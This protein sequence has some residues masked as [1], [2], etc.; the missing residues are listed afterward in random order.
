MRVLLADG[1]STVRSAL[2]VLLEQDPGL[3][4]VG[5]AG[6]THSLLVLAG[7]THPDLLLLDWELP[8]LHAQGALLSLRQISSVPFVIALSG[9]PELGPSALA[10]G[11]HAFVSK[12]D[13]PEHLLAAIDVGRQ[14]RLSLKA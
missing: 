13:P 1:R 12:G 8:G 7:T 9:R 5:E 10:T 4:V 3:C 6:D 14:S 2:R 11:A